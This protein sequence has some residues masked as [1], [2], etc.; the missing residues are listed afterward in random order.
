MLSEL[1]EQSLDVEHRIDGAGVTEQID[2]G[3]VQDELFFDVDHDGVELGPIDQLN[4]AVNVRL[5][6]GEPGIEINRLDRLGFE[7]D[8]CSSVGIVHFREVGDLD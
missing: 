7:G 4:Q 6:R 1:V 5:G 3:L 8:E 2:L